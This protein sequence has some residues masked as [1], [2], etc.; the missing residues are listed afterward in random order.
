MDDNG[1]DMLPPLDRKQLQSYLDEVDDAVN[2]AVL[3]GDPEIALQWAQSMRQEVQIRGLAL[4]K[5]LYEL[6]ERWS[7]FEVAGLN[8]PFEQVIRDNL[9]YSP[10]TTKKYVSMW[11]MIVTYLLP[12]NVTDDIKDKVLRKGTKALSLITPSVKDAEG[13]FPWEAV[14]RSS[15]VH[16]LR[17]LMATDRTSCGNRRTLLLFPDGTLKVKRGT[18]GQAKSFG[19]LNMNSDDPDIQD[20]VEYLIRT[21]NVMELV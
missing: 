3:Q 21:L 12:A 6:H 11:E 15:S 18:T 13:D 9:G 2:N 17:D 1:L 10:Q 4:A 19:L 20:A 16:D 14:A 5:L 8:E 7:L